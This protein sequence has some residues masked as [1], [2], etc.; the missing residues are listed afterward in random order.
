MRSEQQPCRRRRESR[1]FR[2]GR[3]NLCD[4]QT[5]NAGILVA[6]T[7]NRIEGNNLSRTSRG[8]DV[9]AAGNFIIKNSATSS[10]GGGTPSA[11]YSFNGFTQTNGAIITATGTISADPWANFSC[12]NLF[13]TRASMK[14]TIR[15][16]SRIALLTA[17]VI[18]HSSPVILAQGSLTPPGAP[19]PTMKS[20][21]QVE[22]RTPISSAPFTI[23]SP[24][25]YYLTSNLT[26]SS[27]DAIVI[28]SSNVTLDLRGFTINST[29]TAA[30]GSGHGIDVTSG[31]NIEIR[32]GF[33]KSPVTANG[34]SFSLNGGFH[35]GIYAGAS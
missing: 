22:A 18:L 3:D 35:D 23:S 5:T 6:G 33:I 30:A 28:A 25:S 13:P 12:T 11:N 17:G 8:I 10:T 34:N 21:D 24:G 2:C 15:T 19:A 16:S 7:D 31:N 32:D 1:T 14:Q 9:T 26:V 29:S 27:G 4:F 20:L